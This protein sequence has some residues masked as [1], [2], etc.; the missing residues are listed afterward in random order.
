M[1]VMNKRILSLFIILMV[2]ALLI[3]CSSDDAKNNNSGETNSLEGHVSIDGSGTVYP[4][5]AKLAEEYMTTKEA[6][7]SV[8]VSRAG[9][10][11]GFKKFLIE[12]GTDFNNAS[13]NIKEEEIALAKELKI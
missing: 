3:A 10:S 4:L 2:G 1:I 6:N 11:A 9:T 7:V 5:M 12:N 8:E 13:R